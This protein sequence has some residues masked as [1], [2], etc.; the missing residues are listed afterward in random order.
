MQPGDVLLTPNWCYH[1]HHN[2]SG[3]EAYWIDTLDIPLAEYLGPI[4]FEPHPD[5][6][7]KCDVVA[8]QSPMRF[9]YADCK[10]KLIAAAESSPGIGRLEL[11]P[12]YLTTFDRVAVHL[13]AGAHWQC[14][15]STANQIFVVIEG[16]GRSIAAG[17]TFSWRA[18]DMMAVPSWH[19]HSHEAATDTVLP[20][21]SDLPLMRMLGWERTG[22]RSVRV[23]TMPRKKT[24]RWR[25]SPAIT[26]GSYPGDLLS[27]ARRYHAAFGLT[28]IATP[29]FQSLHEKYRTYLAHACSGYLHAT[30]HFFVSIPA[31][32]HRRSSDVRGV[33]LE[34]Q[35]HRLSDRQ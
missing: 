9:A 5:T 11:G 14:P 34:R 15:R 12:P 16:S 35:L 2:Q 18:G 23:R 1:G 28:A 8:A 26:P 25:G 33:R 27:D 30:D 24:V 32:S 7:E 21:M 3:E 10:P 19:D 4:F 22:P 13:E 6:L 20:R 17:E 29:P 31:D